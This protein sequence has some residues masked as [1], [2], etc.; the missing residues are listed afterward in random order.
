[1]GGAH[2]VAC[3]EGSLFYS[4][5]D[6]GFPAATGILA[7]AEDSEGAIWIG[8]GAGVYRFQRGALKEV[9]RRYVYALAASSG[10]VIASVSPVGQDAPRDPL[11]F[12]I[13]WNGSAWRPKPRTSVIVIP[14]TP[15]ATSR[16]FTAS[17]L[18]G[19]IIESSRFTHDPPIHQ[20]TCRF[21]LR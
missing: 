12:R 15:A 5:R 1:M 13:R 20:L 2:D 21:H 9:M 8:S 19:L 17:R 14:S 10:G 11:L 7:I 4:L 6:F 18:F 16:S 3:F